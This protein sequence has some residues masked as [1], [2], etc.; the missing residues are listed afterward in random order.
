MKLLAPKF[1]FRP[2]GEPGKERSYRVVLQVE[3]DG[4][5]ETLGWL[6]GSSKTGF[7]ITGELFDIATNFGLRRE[8]AEAMADVTFK[9]RTEK[10]M[11]ELRP[12]WRNIALRSDRAL[13]Q[14][15][16]DKVYDLLVAFGAADQEVERDSFVYFH[17]HEAQSISNEYRFQGVFGFGGKFR[18][19][20]RSF[21]VDYYCENANPYL[22]WLQA[23]LNQQL[24]QLYIEEYGP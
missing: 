1:S 8:A 21:Y 20:C 16:A 12:T 9:S 2:W 3:A 14:A 15:V 4:P 22:D 11:T 10:I 17:S 5:L 23:D 18:N 7:I 6:Q 24:H 19:D 13:T